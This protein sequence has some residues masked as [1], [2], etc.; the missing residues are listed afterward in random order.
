M[1]L[2]HDPC[3]RGVAAAGAAA[4]LLLASSGAYGYAAQPS[5]APPDRRH[6]AKRHRAKRH[7]LFGY[8]CLSYEKAHCEILEYALLATPS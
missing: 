7:T 8:T 5:W 3:V 6:A 1:G 2:Q 4:L